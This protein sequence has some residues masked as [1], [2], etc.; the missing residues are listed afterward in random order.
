M[1]N[2]LDNLYYVKA[3]ALTP[4]YQ[5]AR[6]LAIY[7][8]GW[9]MLRLEITQGITFLMP[10]DELGSKVGD[11]RNLTPIYAVPEVQKRLDDAKGKMF[12]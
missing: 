4:G 1:E 3:D 5:I 6:V 7:P 10:L 9:C 11:L 8:N 12:N 2:Y